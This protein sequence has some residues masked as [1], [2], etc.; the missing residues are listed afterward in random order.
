MWPSIKRQQQ[1]GKC[2]Q[3]LEPAYLQP[4]VFHLFA[5]DGV[6]CVHYLGPIHKLLVA[7]V[8]GTDF[9]QSL[10]GLAS[11][12]NVALIQMIR[13][14]LQQNGNFYHNIYTLH[15]CE[16]EH[17]L[18]LGMQTITATILNQR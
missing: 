2:V 6:N 12:R 10:N 18:H 15:G 16:E 3:D 11:N 8:S 9:Y 14:N 5:Q 4:S 17:A 7:I 13:K 1:R